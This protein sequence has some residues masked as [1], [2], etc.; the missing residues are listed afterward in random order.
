MEKGKTREATAS[1]T[2]VREGCGVGDG[3]KHM[4][5]SSKVD[6]VLCS[7]LEFLQTQSTNTLSSQTITLA[8]PC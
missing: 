1:A 7:S 6:R 5:L 8:E 2:G 3:E 4:L